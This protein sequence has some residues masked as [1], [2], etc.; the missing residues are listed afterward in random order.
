LLTDLVKDIIIRGGENISSEEV[1]NAIYLDDRIAEAAAVPVPDDLLGELVAVAVSLRP[2]AKATPEQIIATAH[3]R[4][5]SHA[6][7]AFVWVSD[8]LLRE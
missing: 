3:N 1:E 8:D 2:G 5:R 4:L 7:P 6:R